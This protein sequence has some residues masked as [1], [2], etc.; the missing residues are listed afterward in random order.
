[1][2]AAVFTP[3]NP[4]MLSTFQGNVPIQQGQEIIQE[5]MANSVV[6]QLA[7]YEEMDSLEKEFDVFLGGLGAYWVDEGQRIQTTTAKWGKATLRAKKLAVILPVSREYL[8]Y[9]QKEFFNKMK[10]FISEAFFKKFDAATILGV[11]NPYTQS[12]S[13]SVG[14]R[15]IEGDLNLA[16][17]DAAVAVLNDAGFEPN[18]AISKVQNNSLIRAIVRDDNGLKTRLY[19]GTNI[20]GV[21]V[22]D[23]HRDITEFQKGTLVLGDFDHAYYGIPYTMNYAISQDATL[24]TVKDE[25]GEVLNLF[26]RDMVALRVVMDVAFM[27]VKDEAFSM[28]EPTTP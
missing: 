4:V 9:K 20:D 18:A 6:M 22:F 24:T 26:E 7:K 16:N 11:D 5:V 17:F 10:P 28:I 15:K 12:I 2:P 3:A 14:T 19:D 13:A 8:H 21:P 25:D 27:I 23:I 1:M